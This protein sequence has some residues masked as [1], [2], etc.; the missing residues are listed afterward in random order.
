MQRIALV[1]QTGIANVFLVRRYN[2]TAEGR[3]AVRLLQH[4]FSPCEYFARGM[5]EAGSSL[6]VYSCNKA[7]DIAEQQWTEGLDDCP[8]REQAMPLRPV[9]RERR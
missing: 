8:F 3:N 9:E 6:K 7:G 2:T 5:L 4:A 1:Y